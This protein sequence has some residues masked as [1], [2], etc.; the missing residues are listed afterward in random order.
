MLSHFLPCVV[1]EA[2]KPGLMCCRRDRS[3]H[4]DPKVG[5]L[6]LLLESPSCSLQTPSFPCLPVPVLYTPQELIP[7][8][9]RHTMAS[10]PLHPHPLTRSH[11]TED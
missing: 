10:E 8:R 6:G 5:L 4:K 1:S 9:V 7:H 2:K 3:T 11:H